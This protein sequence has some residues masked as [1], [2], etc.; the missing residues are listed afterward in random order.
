MQ[1]KLLRVIQEREVL[2]LGGTVPLK[3]NVRFIAATN[4][5]VQEMVRQG[6]FRQDLYFRLNVVNLHIPFAGRAG[7]KLHS[8][9]ARR[10]KRKSNPGC[11]NS[12]H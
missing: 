7:K 1:M 6:G 11:A 8:R 9:S 3:V 5:D 12:R 10:S 4:R 2:P